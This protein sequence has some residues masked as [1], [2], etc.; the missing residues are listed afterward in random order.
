[1]VVSQLPILAPTSTSPLVENASVLVVDDNPQVLL[2]LENVFSSHHYN[3]KTAIS[4]EHAKELLCHFSPEVIVCD[5]MMPGANGYELFK[6]LQQHEKWCHIPFIF[7]T[8][9]TDPK[10]MRYAKSLGCD[11]FLT[12]PFSTDDLLA[13]VAGKVIISRKRKEIEEKEKEQF[14]RRVIHTLSHEFRTPL[15]SVNTGAE[16]LLEQREALQDQQV[17]HLLGSILRGGQRLQNL[18]DD[19]MLLQH[20]DSGYASATHKR[21]H[22]RDSLARISHTAIK[23]FQEKCQ[24]WNCQVDITFS[25]DVEG[26][27]STDIDAYDVHIVDA[28]ERVLSNAVKFG[29]AQTPITV[30]V[31]KDGDDIVTSIRDKGPGMSQ[32]TVR[33]AW[34]AFD[35]INREKHEQQGCGFG[36]AI[37]KYFI[38]INGGEIEFLTPCDGEGLEVLLR[39]PLDNSSK[40]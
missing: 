30:R 29:G 5:V 4:A 26:E 27:H 34:T 40:K 33:K 20:I 25:I 37:A 9:I 18:V 13:A 6:E 31:F 23:R 17:E 2:V 28:I 32:S 12:K 3:T 1:M 14:R 38:D 15:V 11:D 8:A 10:E 19:F 7:L 24:E 21:F 22:R 16:L 35:Q 36:L 39:F